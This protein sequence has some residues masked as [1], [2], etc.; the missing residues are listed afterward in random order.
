[1]VPSA[2]GF[3]GPAPFQRSSQDGDHHGDRHDGMVLAKRR[4]AWASSG[5]AALY[6][7]HTL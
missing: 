5:R 6:V 7:D 4:Q 2:D 3:S 1:M